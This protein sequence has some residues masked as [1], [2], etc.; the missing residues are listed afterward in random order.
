MGSRR[1]WRGLAAAGT[2]GSGSVGSLQPGLEAAAAAAWARCGWESR[3]RRRRLAL[4]F[5]NEAPALRF[6]NKGSGSSM[7]MV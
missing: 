2:R 7:C 6:G 3:Q 5:G 4:R 1:C